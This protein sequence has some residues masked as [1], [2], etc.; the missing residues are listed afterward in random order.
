MVPGLGAVVERERGLK[1][2]RE[3]LLGYNGA[4]PTAYVLTRI[5]KRAKSR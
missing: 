5:S 4:T 3:R 1:V 2:V